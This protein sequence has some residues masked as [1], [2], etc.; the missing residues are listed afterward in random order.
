M[1]IDLRGISLNSSTMSTCVF[2]SF[3]SSVLVGTSTTLILAVFFLMGRF[4]REQC[5]RQEVFGTLTKF[6][7]TKLL[8]DV[9]KLFI[10]KGGWFFAHKS[11]ASVCV[12]GVNKAVQEKH[13][14]LT[15]NQ[16]NVNMLVIFFFLLCLGWFSF[17][18]HGS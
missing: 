1:S 6:A 7:M 14:R 8:Q 12:L 15:W 18:Y 2:S 9:V 10:S 5:K 17:L 3:F 16:L 13:T 4:L 11:L